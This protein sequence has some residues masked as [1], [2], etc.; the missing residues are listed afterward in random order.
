VWLPWSFSLVILLLVVIKLWF[1]RY[2]IYRSLKLEKLS[3]FRLI[4]LTVGVTIFFDLFLT[5]LQYLTWHYSAFSR[6]LLPPYQPLSYF[7]GYSFF[8]FWLADL[9]S[10]AIT[11]L[12]FSV[13]KIIKKL[14]RDTGSGEE[15]S[16][17]LLLSLVLGWPKMLIFI[18]L[19]LV[20]SFLYILINSVVFK[21]KNTS[22]AVPSL[23]SALI[24][25]FF[26]FYLVNLLGL[27]VL[28]V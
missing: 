9:L 3:F 2:Q 5:V 25:F 10:L 17:I 11:L 24:V 16:L 27:S 8:N 4:K 22:V 20:L 12:F 18:P 26:G 28:T 1:K 21:K 14:K 13:F 7:W 19:F 6:F 15:L 23:V